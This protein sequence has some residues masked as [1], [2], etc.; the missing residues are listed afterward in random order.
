MACSHGRIAFLTKLLV[1]ASFAERRKAGD[2]GVGNTGQSR[3]Y[4][5]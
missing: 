5:E 1:A 2:A 3:Q 4:D